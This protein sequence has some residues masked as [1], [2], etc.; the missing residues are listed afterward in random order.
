VLVRVGTVGITGSAGGRLA[1]GVTGS[2]GEA[3][4]D[5]VGRGIHVDGR[6][7]PE[8]GVGVDGVL[9][10]EDT[11]GVT[12]GGGKFDGDTTTV[13]VV[14]P[15]LAV[16]TTTAVEGLHAAGVG[17]GGPEVDIGAHVVD[18][19]DTAGAGV[20]GTVRQSSS[21]SSEDAGDED[22]GEEHFE[23]VERTV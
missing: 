16:S 13:G 3:V 6:Q 15:A 18:E 11:V 9:E 2:D 12:L 14:L 7:V 8:E 5:E 22:V 19:L 21:S 17:S 4:L 23:V 1:A 20:T 10:L